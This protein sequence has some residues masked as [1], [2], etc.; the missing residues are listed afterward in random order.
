MFSK[1]YK[2]LYSTHLFCGL[3]YIHT[4]LHSFAEHDK[5]ERIDKKGKKMRWK[6][7]SQGENIAA[8]YIFSLFHLYFFSRSN[9][10]IV[11]ILP[12]FICVC[13]LLAT[14]LFSLCYFFFGSWLISPNEFQ[15]YPRNVST[16]HN[17]LCVIQHS[18][19]LLLNQVFFRFFSCTIKSIAAIL[20]VLRL[21]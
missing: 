3:A 5:N 14:F 6:W 9:V 7:N 4:I 21:I 10:L 16:I 15:I 1:R 11:V 12:D 13:L 19:V 18:I 2:S 8:K 20:F 17:T